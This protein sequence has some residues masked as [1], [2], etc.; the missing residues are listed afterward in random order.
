MVKAIK[1]VIKEDTILDVYFLDGLVKRYDVLN[2]SHIFPQLNDLKI[3]S[4]F[5]KARLIGSSV[6]I[7][8]D[9]LDIDCETIYEDGSDVSEE[10]N[11]IDNV[12]L[13][14]KIKEKRIQKNLTQE[15]LANSIGVDQG[16][17]SKIE[18]GIGNPS[19]KTL[20]RICDGLNAK[21]LLKII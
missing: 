18:K 21:L 15:E 4:L 20:Q 19:L 5:K 3:P 16:D 11:D 14:Y 2:L 13:G 9:E 12:V 6:I 10:Y 8:N 17:L 1:F 7:W